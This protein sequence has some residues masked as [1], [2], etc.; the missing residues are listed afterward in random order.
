MR[1][2]LCGVS[3]VRFFGTSGLLKRTWEERSKWGSGARGRD[4]YNRSGSLRRGPRKRSGAPCSSVEHTIRGRVATASSKKRRG[5]EEE[6]RPFLFFRDAVS[7]RGLETSLALAQAQ[8]E[9]S[10][11]TIPSATYL[12]L[13]ASP[14]PELR[15][16]LWVK[17]RS[18]I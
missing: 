11:R 6:K 2:C 4:A 5:S 16:L 13:R 7:P 12:Y 18:T 8:I 3:L 9:Y 17:V 14:L 1:V 10:S 15:K